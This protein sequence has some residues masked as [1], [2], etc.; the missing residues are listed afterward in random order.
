MWSLELASSWVR[1]DAA[2][3]SHVLAESEPL[4]T[5]ALAMLLPKRPTMACARSVDG[6]Q[7]YNEHITRSFDNLTSL[8]P[9]SAFDTDVFIKLQP[10]I[11]ERFNLLR[12]AKLAPTFYNRAKPESRR[13][14]SRIEH[15]ALA[16]FASGPPTTGR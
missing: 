13:F 1:L 14:V 12:F 5:T 2:C 4:I 3:G 8:V 7:S 9:L 16:S 15:G 11:M 10:D 6:T